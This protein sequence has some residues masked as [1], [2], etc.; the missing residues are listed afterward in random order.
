MYPLTYYILLKNSERDS[1]SLCYRLAREQS[2]VCIRSIY[3]QRRATKSIQGKRF[4]KFNLWWALVTIRK[5]LTDEVFVFAGTRRESII[6]TRLLNHWCGGR[7]ICQSQYGAKKNRKSKIYF[8]IS[9]TQQLSL[10]VTKVKN[11]D[12][13]FLSCLPVVSLIFFQFKLL[14]SGAKFSSVLKMIRPPFLEYSSIDNDKDWI[15]DLCYLNPKEICHL[16][17]RWMRDETSRNQLS[18]KYCLRKK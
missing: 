13:P 11:Y 2:P 5:S 7:S 3:A 8:T 9:G 18:F 1:L 15:L 4:I 17:C 12:I 10:M 6:L 16:S 14:G